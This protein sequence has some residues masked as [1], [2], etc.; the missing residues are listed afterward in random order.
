[1]TRCSRLTLLYMAAVDQHT[2]QPGCL[3]ILLQCHAK[4]PSLIGTKQLTEHRDQ[5]VLLYSP[6]IYP[7]EVHSTC[8]HWDPEPTRPGK[9]L[10]EGSQSL[11]SDNHGRNSPQRTPKNVESINPARISKT[12]WSRQCNVRK[13]TTQ[14]VALDT[15]QGRGQRSP[16]PPAA[17]QLQLAV[18][19]QLLQ[20]VDVAAIR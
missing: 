15:H 5:Q 19:R 14:T 16:A 10:T 13:S 7:R 17:Y 9:A 4:Q 18:A 6:L 3:S 11:R 20:P 2:N 8:E 12:L 1:M